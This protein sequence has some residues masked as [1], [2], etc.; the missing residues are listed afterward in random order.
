MWA[1]VDSTANTV[2]AEIINPTAVRHDDVVHPSQIFST[3]SASELKDIGVYSMTVEDVNTQYYNVDW[4]DIS[5]TVDNDAGTV[6]KHP[7]KTEKDLE[8][9]KRDLTTEIN[10]RAYTILLQSDWKILRSYETSINNSVANTDVQQ[11]VLD[12]RES[13]RTTATA[14]KVQIAAMT[15]IANT[16]NYSTTAGWPAANTSTYDP[17]WDKILVAERDRID[18]ILRRRLAIFGSANTEFHPY[19]SG[20]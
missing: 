14:K 9:A 17:A 11:A 1:R 16:A 6:I 19:S 20:E 15:N 2:S 4:A 3:W 13:V 10:E 18:T 5:Y 12:Y 8:T 7:A